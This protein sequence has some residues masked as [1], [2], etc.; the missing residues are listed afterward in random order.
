MIH[1]S[2][3]SM[4]PRWNAIEPPSGAGAGR[5]ASATSGWTDSGDAGSTVHSPRKSGLEVGQK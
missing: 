3:T 2:P 4:V 1:V 5:S